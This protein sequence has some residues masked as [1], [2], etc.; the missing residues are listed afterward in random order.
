M[1]HWRSLVVLSTL[2]ALAACE[3]EPIGGDDAGDPLPSLD[4]GL[5]D[6][7]EQVDDD[8]GV[9]SPDAGMSP[10]GGDV[11]FDAGSMQ[12]TDAGPSDGGTSVVDGGSSDG[13]F[14]GSPR[15]AGSGLLVCD[16]FEN[17]TLDT[18]LWSTL[19]NNGTVTI[20]STRAARGTHSLHIH[21]AG[22]AGTNVGIRET[23]T[24]PAQ[25]DTLFGRAF[26]YLTATAQVHATLFEST[27]TI[28]GTNV[29]AF[30]RYGFQF[31]TLLANYDTIGRTT[32]YPIHSARTLPLNQW[33]CVEWQFKGDTNE[34]HLWLNGSE[35]TD[36]AV[37]ANH[38]PPWAAP[39]FT[40]VFLGWH[41]YSGTDPTPT[42]DLWL[43]GVAVNGSRIG[44]AR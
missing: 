3:T 20:D 26:V 32:D 33:S 40:N 42:I 21:A 2:G 28:P 14:Y 43:D 37:Q 9:P 36:I 34:L 22:S 4:A 1:S 16:D 6:G 17:T 13:G 25:N 44:C 11:P 10:D 23:R 38:S 27:G 35:V 39:A 15:C 12:T 5:A 29:T 41:L 7:G 18:N 8:G 30:Y 19:T 31:H 24:F